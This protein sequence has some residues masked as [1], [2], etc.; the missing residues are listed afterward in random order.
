MVRLVDW[1]ATKFALYVSTAIACSGCGPDDPATPAT[2]DSG[3]PPG[4]ET[5]YPGRRWSVSAPAYGTVIETSVEITMSD[6]VVLVGDVSY[7]TDLGTGAR[8]SGDFPVLLTQNPYGPVFGAASGEIFV[9]HG[10]IF[11]SIDVRGTSRSGGVHDMFG[12]REAEDGAA[13][14]TWASTLPG[15]DGKVGLHGCSQLGINQIETAT[16]L[17]PN[18]PVKAMIPACASGDFYRD[19]AFDNGIATT[20]GSLLVGNDMTTGGDMTYYRAYWK[21][22]DRLARAPA[23]ASADIPMLL[24]SGWHEPGTIGSLELYV[25]LQNLAAGRPQSAPIRDADTVS[26]RVQVILGDWGHA[27]GLDHGIQ[28]QW[29]DTWIKGI[30]TGLPTNTKTPL[31]LAELGGTKRWVNAKSYPVVASHTPLYLSSAR[32]LSRSAEA[33]AG[34]DQ[35][36]WVPDGWLGGS[37]EYATEP[38]ASGGMLAGPV[39]ARLEVTSSSGNV[40]LVVDVFDRAPD[41]TRAKITHGSILGSL[42]RMNAQASWTDG[43]GLPMRPFLTLDQDEPLTPGAPTELDVPLWPTVWSIE[44]GH[45]IVVRIATQPAAADCGALLALPVG[46]NLT[47][48]QSAS[49]SGGVYTLHRGGALSSLLSLPL[50]DHGALATAEA[51]VSPTGELPDPPPLGAVEYPLPID[52]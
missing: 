48:P 49:L 25:A 24:W 8:A 40:Q 11:A 30:D 51:A 16:K 52:W 41:G 45:S 2:G 50:L 38:F 47:S 19:T 35:L 33:V 3:V 13:L 31:H 17:G 27:G 32:G 21:E 22:R 29:Y 7:P 4:P 34:Q 20:V 42:R 36:S 18:S 46:C 5:K 6:G 39:A 14:V 9:T 15:S 37:I 26:G 10:Y 12:P 23:I 28:L 43:S 44:P 1:R